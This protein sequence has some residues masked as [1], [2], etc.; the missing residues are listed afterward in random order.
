MEKN[1]RKTP[2][3]LRAAWNS[4]MSNLRKDEETLPGDV[5]VISF[6]QKINH[7]GKQ[8]KYTIHFK[9]PDKSWM[10]INVIYIYISKMGSVRFPG[11]IGDPLLY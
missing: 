1:F 11:P 10:Y 3:F 8:Q 6:Q 5:D 9:S 7:H 4:S 2:T